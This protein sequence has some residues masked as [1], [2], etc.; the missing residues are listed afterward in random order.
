[1]DFLNRPSPARGVL[2]AL[3]EL[4]NEARDFVAE[5]LASRSFVPGCDAWH[6]GWDEQFSRK[7]GERG[8]VGMTL[9]TKYGGGGRTSVERYVV[10]EEL[11][12]AGAPLAAHWA[13]DR[14]MGP[15]IVRFG[16]ESQRDHFLPE[17][18]AGRYFFAIGMSEPDSGSDLASVRTRGSQHAGGWRLTGTK[19]WT[20]GAHKAHAIMVLAR[21]SPV[22]EANRHAGLSQFIVAT[23]SPGLTVRPVGDLTG[24]HYFNEV[25]FD[26]VFV[27]EARV[28]GTIGDGWNQVTAELDHERGGPER[29][30][31]TYPLIAY[32]VEQ[33]RMNADSSHDA[34]VGSLIARLW[35]LHQMSISVAADLSEGSSAAVPAALVKELGTRF[36]SEIIETARFILEVEPDEHAPDEGARLLAQAVLHAPGFTIRG[37][38]NEILRGVIAKGLGLR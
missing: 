32:V 30:L 19:V 18:S 29:F 37:G 4:R 8:F 22:D 27:P 12:A 1:M 34:A 36:E 16:T 28:L 9:P 38:T 13:A 14:Q 2:S 10:V 7:L 23:D 3:V 15:A 25:V 5:E 20:T 24:A 31:S 33:L 21:T 17:I 26:D 6:I 35:T 11:L